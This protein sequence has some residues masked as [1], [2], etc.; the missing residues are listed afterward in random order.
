MTNNTTTARVNAAR[1]EMMNKFA[2]FRA[3]AE[4]ATVEDLVDGADEGVR[5]TAASFFE[6]LD[7]VGQITG[8]TTLKHLVAQI[9]EESV[10]EE[11]GLLHI[12][13]VAASVHQVILE[14]AQEMEDCFCEKEAAALRE[15]VKGRSI[16]T[17]FT[18][19]VCFITGKL[20]RGCGKVL[21]FAEK[22]LIGK[23]VIKAIK[24]VAHV[25]RAGVKV[26]VSV[27]THAL[28]FV[29]A[30]AIIIADYLIGFVRYALMKVKGFWEAA[31]LKKVEDVLEEDEEEPV[32]EQ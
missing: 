15:L 18:G 30:S 13:D 27:A 20:Y 25:V 9:I 10:S 31:H 21:G 6:F 12:N 17:M 23:S 26:V 1:E 7:K 32:T 11:D 22:H 2:A 16:W 3:V 19:T 29:G 28:S 8:A 24:G 14:K 5:G 4:G